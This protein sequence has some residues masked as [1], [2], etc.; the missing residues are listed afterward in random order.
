[1]NEELNAKYEKL[2]SILTSYGSLA[3]AFSGGVDS[4]FLLKVAYDALGDRVI[5]VT[6][7]S[8]SF[9]ERELREAA[10]YCAK[11]GIRH[12]I[13]DS[14]ELDIDG[15]AQ[16]PPNRCY[17]CKT[18]LFTKIGE[19][20]K[21]EGLAYIAEGSNLDDEGDY[22]PGL[23]AVHELGI[24]SPLREAEL[25]KNDIREISK[26]L[27]LPTWDKQS[28]ACLSSRFVYGETISEE[29]LRRVDK[30]EQLLLDLGFSQVRVRVHGETGEQARIE[31]NVA[32]FSKLMQDEVREKI[33][34]GFR[35][36][37]FIYISLDL[38]GYRTGSMNQT[39]GYFI[40]YD[41]SITNLSI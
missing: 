4:T 17:L 23:M 19:I 12:F 13:T 37:G 40:D 36:I 11:N 22:R 34:A 30:A 24:K 28:F 18:E 27:G 33:L 20:A 29:K 26:S 8:C 39:H 14:E 1:M 15:F 25:S 5:A 32:E 38:A 41:N 16:N 10:D 9:P 21:A 35:K 7:R 31:I 2:K 6:A 3:V